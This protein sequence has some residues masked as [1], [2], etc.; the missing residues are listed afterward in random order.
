MFGAT[1][2]NDER[3]D[4]Y[5]TKSFRYQYCTYI[6]HPV[7]LERSNSDWQDVKVKYVMGEEGLKI[8]VENLTKIE[9]SE[10]TGVDGITN[11]I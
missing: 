10:D 3:L 9:S 2:G 8:W 6:S 7:L 1:A 5:L 4:V 11:E